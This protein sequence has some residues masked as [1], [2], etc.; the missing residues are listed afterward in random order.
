MEA[1][2]ARWRGWGLAFLLALSLGLN[3][4]QVW[5]GL[6]VSGPLAWGTDE[7][8]PM[9]PVVYVRRTFVTGGW[10]HK[11]PAFHFL[12]LA[13][14]YAP[15]LLYVWLR[16]GFA[17]PGSEEWPY[18][19]AEPQLVLT[20][21]VVIAR[22]VSVLM[23]TAVVGLVWIAGRRLFGERAAFFAAFLVAVSAP[24]VYYSHTSNL[25]VPY[26]FWFMLGFLCYLRLLERPRLRDGAG[27]G[28]CMALAVATKDQAYGLLPFLPLVLLW[29]WVRQA[30]GSTWR[31]RVAALPWRPAGAAVLGF[32]AVYLLA[33]NVVNN[34]TGYLRHVAY[35]TGPGSAPYSQFAHTPAGHAALL[36]RTVT[37]LAESLGVPAFLAS[38]GGVA[39]GIM[40]F[41]RLALSLL[42]PLAS[43]YL[44][45]LALILYVYPRFL[46]PC[47][48]ILALFAGQL[49]DVVW[50]STGWRRRLARPVV[51]AVLGY[52]AL[53]GASVDWLLRNDPRY[54]AEAW[55]GRHVRP[56]ARVE[57]YGPPQ[58][59]PRF[60]PG[61]GVDRR[62]L[63][64]YVEGKFRVRAPDYV[65]L[66]WAYYR[67][68][69][70]DHEDDFDQEEFIAH[71]W[72]GS[73]GYRAV[74]DFQ[75][76]P[77]FGPSLIPGLGARVTIFA[78]DQQRVAR[79]GVR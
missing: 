3:A 14:L 6:P 76:D 36:G 1:R 33:A 41:R 79:D 43:Y 21:L 65:V 50:A 66:T 20:A 26:L 37:L 18:G 62:E 12:L 47:V 35:I 4:Y 61:L 34:W 7:I 48:A 30:S 23:G 29:T 10:T 60:P 55:I 44:T 67:R 64:G 49:L 25:D 28:A 9:G 78:R 27:L 22:V 45:F 59:L 42:A 63:R 72:D 68:I 51:C 2:G 58:Y 24:F 57:A 46:L 39:Y 52:S 40:R 19:L 77:V 16:G 15:V 11:Y 71:L 56:T 5:W 31:A 69:T 32:A 73:L 70:A 17:Y 8:A 13:V 38:V 75:A 54:E 53:S 74:A